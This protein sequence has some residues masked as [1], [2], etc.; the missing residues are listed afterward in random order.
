MDGPTLTVAD[1]RRSCSIERYLIGGMGRNSRSTVDSRAKS[2]GYSMVSL[3]AFSLQ[4]TG[5]SV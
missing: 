3:I 1:S 4:S 2:I 5:R